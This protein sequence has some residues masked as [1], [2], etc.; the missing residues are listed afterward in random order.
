MQ[1]AHWRDMTSSIVSNRKSA[2]LDVVGERLHGP[3]QVGE[4]VDPGRILDLIADVWLVQ[5]RVRIAVD[6]EQM[7]AVSNF[8]IRDERKATLANDL[9]H[10]H[11]VWGDEMLG[12][13]GVHRF[14]RPARG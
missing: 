5:D 12:V 1:V 11:E 13:A 14:Q 6:H 3:A 4:G 9:H 8:E 7:K 10:R 2:S